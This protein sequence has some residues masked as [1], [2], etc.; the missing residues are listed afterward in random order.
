MS[1]AAGVHS[2][3]CRSAW[4]GARLIGETFFSD[5]DRKLDAL[6]PTGAKLGESAVVRES[7]AA[8]GVLRSVMA[9]LWL[10]G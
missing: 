9:F 3:G 8:R 6:E 4:P 2:G 5:P 10:D 7:V 1:S